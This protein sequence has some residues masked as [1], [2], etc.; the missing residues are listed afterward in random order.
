MHDD[1]ACPAGPF[2][3]QLPGLIDG[4]TKSQGDC[5]VDIDHLLFNQHGEKRDVEVSQRCRVCGPPVTV[6]KQLMDL[7]SANEAT[8]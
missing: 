3:S 7:I 2:S 6:H 1:A 8:H 5:H 4:C